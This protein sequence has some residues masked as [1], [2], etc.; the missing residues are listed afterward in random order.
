[1][2]IQITASDVPHRLWRFGRARTWLALVLLPTA[3]GLA[4]S[5][6]GLGQQSARAAINAR[7]TWRADDGKASGKWTARFKVTPAGALSGS[8]AL[9]G[10]GDGSPAEIEGAVDNGQVKFGLVSTR[11]D[12][13]AGKQSLC[14]FEGTI[15][16]V[17]ME[18]TFSD[19]QGREG[20]WEGWWNSGGRKVQG[21]GEP[22]GPTVILDQ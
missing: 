13:T 21:R 12:S 7:G 20:Q 18:G 19:T 15:R 6:P 22:A 1:M 10:M 9:E 17:R 4:V 11:A 14:T 8:I 3:L 16:G 2:A 5:R